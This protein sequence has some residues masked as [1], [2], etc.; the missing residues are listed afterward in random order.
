VHTTFIALALALGAPDEPKFVASGTGEA[1]HTG[2]LVGLSLESATVSAPVGARAVGGLVALTRADQPRP[3]LPTGAQLVSTSGERVRGALVGGDA[4]ALAFRPACADGDWKVPFDSVAAVWLVAPPAD[5][6]TDPA[7]YAWLAGTP[8]RDVLLFRNGDRAR[9]AITGFD[10]V[11]VTFAADGGAARDVPL[12]DLA[13][14]G[15]NPRFARPRKPKGPYARLT[16]ADGT[17]FDATAV[18]LKE[19]EI[20]AKPLLGP[21]V[22]VPVAKVIALDVFQGGAV[23]LSDLKP[24]KSEVSGFVGAG[25]PWAADRT[26]RGNPLRVLTPTGESTFDK[27]IGTHPRTTLTYALNGEYVRFE[28]L[29]GLDAKTGKRGRAVV[30]VLLDGKPADLPDLKALTAGP[31]VPVKLDV[32]GAKELTLEVDFGATGDVQADVNWVTARVIRK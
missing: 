24:T 12:K 19:G 14:V 8:P 32:R 3:P 2:P 18:A 16:L 13:A 25:W 9:G 15:F 21:E 30:R 22:A 7:N 20:V 27:G 6:P 29:V 1:A 10:A 26:V 5:T 28:A 11:S 17:R 23:Y 4:K 31:A